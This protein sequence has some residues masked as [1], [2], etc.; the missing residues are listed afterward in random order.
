M[1]MTD[2]SGD[3]AS[4][5]ITV[6]D[7]SALSRAGNRT[8]PHLRRLLL[9]LQQYTD[10]ASDGVV[11]SRHRKYIGTEMSARQR[12]RKAHRLRP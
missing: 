7:G 5:P 8:E 6:Q 9:T 11:V 3:P 2:V 12:E 10:H 4:G 1:M